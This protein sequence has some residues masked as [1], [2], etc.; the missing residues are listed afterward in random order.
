[1]ARQLKRL[2]SYPVFITVFA[3]AA[4]MAV[5]CYIWYASRTPVKAFLPYGYELGR[6]ARSIAAGH[7]FASPLRMVDTGPTAWFTP[8]YP[9]LVAGIFKIWGIFSD[10]S[11]LVIEASN[12]AFAALT[13]IP[14]YGIA[15]RTFQTTVA[16]GAAWA[17]VFLPTSLVFPVTWI[18]DTALAA[19]FLALIFWATLAVHDTKAILPW[20]GYGGLWAVGVLINPSLL[21]LFPFLVVWAIWP[22]RRNF[23]LCAKLSAM[24]LLVFALGLVP[25]TVRN[26]RVFG[27]F[28]VFRSNFGLELWLGNNPSVPDTWSPWLHPNDSREEA[29]KYKQMGEIAFMEEKEREAFAFIRTHPADTLHFMFRR[30]L[31]NW[32]AVTDSPADEWSSSPLYLKAFIVM[33]LLLSL[34]TLVGALFAYRE[35]P[36][37]AF[38]YAIVLLVFP[39]IFCLTHS[40]LRYRFPMDPLMMVLAAYGVSYPISL[41]RER[42]GPQPD[43]VT[44]ARPIPTA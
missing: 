35:R 3:F 15:R 40:S 23:S 26:Y 14:I 34:F 27:K 22:S 29:E 37:E 39:L 32:L 43:T 44:P 24:T 2:L 10:T 13:V 25:W 19:L 5:L 36:R 11:R 16:V 7:G 8:I 12:C 20:A 30:F 4:R 6:V 42:T 33:N 9:Y 38:P 21:S 17:W 31:N 41:L 28:I 1:M 18:W